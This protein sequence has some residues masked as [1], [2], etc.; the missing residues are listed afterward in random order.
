MASSEGLAGGIITLCL[1]HAHHPYPPERA[2]VDGI[3][4]DLCKACRSHPIA[5]QFS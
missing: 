3:G 1:R 5:D 4:E 2:E